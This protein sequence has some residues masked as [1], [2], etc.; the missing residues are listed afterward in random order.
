MIGRV[1]EYSV[2]ELELE[3]ALKLVNV[4]HCGSSLLT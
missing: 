4:G 1:V 3:H 2:F